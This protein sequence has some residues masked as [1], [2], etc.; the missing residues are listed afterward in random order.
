[1]R[2][3]AP[4]HL[5]RVSDDEPLGADLGERLGQQ[6]R[7]VELVDWRGVVAEGIQQLV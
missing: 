5:R 3:R 4:A 7:R 1:M 2:A 6:R